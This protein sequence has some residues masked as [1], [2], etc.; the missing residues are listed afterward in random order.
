MHPPEYTTYI[1]YRIEVLKME[2]ILKIKLLAYGFITMLSFPYLVLPENAGISV[3]IF[4]IIQFACLY[5][6][7]PRKKPLL[8]FIPIFILSLNS[9]IFGNTMWQI[10]NFIVIL[11][12]F[13]VM[14]L[15]SCG[16]F[17]FNDNYLITKIL[18]TIFKPLE[19]FNLPFKWCGEINKENT[20]LIKRIIIAIL[21]SLPVLLL[22]L[23]L[24]SSADSVFGNLTE[25][26]FQSFFDLFNDLSGN[27]VFKSIYGIFMGF[28]AFGLITYIYK[29]KLPKKPPA[30]TYVTPA[31]YDYIITENP[32]KSVDKL[33]LNIF[34]S[35]ILIM[36]T[37]FVVI[38]FAYL[39]A[40]ADLPYGLTY[41]EYA[42]KG[43]F[44]LLFLTGL[45]IIIILICTNLTRKIESE[46][47]KILLSYLCA[48]TCILLISSFYRMMLYNQDDGLTRLRFL[49]FGFL[50]FE[51]VGLI[52]TFSYILKPNF[53]I[54]SVYL[55]IALSYYLV[56]N[57]I[58]IDGIVAKS[59]MDRNFSGIT[60]VKTLSSDAAA[61]IARMYENEK[62]SAD[63]KEF[64]DNK[65]IWYERIPKRWQRY[66]LS[67]EGMKKYAKE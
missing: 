38:Q 20:K 5:F 54:I 44:E 26:A 47:T 67:V 14:I 45:N 19:H 40:G 55:A 25:N 12:L 51:A 28:Y 48:V 53:S 42:R 21:I 50:I 41:T 52:F 10:S 34:L 31:N 30:Y 36:Y 35:L 24:L 57:V 58:P 33:I 18:N 62:F 13:A 8:L 56:L 17:N 11:L 59:Q 23:I 4:I 3:P 16:K 64:F 1:V 49:V 27:L 66:N 65:K 29:D 39:F 32:E 6:I 2:K 15:I 43:F 46:F 61:Q 22:M 9:F 7:V 37:I 63:A 60:Y